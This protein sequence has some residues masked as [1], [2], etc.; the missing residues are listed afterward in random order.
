MNSVLLYH[1]AS[2]SYINS[3]VK[4]IFR[5]L[6]E[7]TNLEKLYNK[8]YDYKFVSFCDAEYDGNRIEREKKYQW[9]LSIIWRQSNL[10]VKKKGR[11]Y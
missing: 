5:Y 10:M 1:I 3:I 11:N 9:W 6:K 4:R 8:L 7:T 2:R